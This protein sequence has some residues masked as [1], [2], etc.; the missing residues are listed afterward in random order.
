MRT[1]FEN[2]I[3]DVLVRA[4]YTDQLKVA[5]D[6]VRISTAWRVEGTLREFAKFKPVNMWFSYPVHALDETGVLADIQIEEA[7]NSKNSPWKKNFEKKTEKSKETKAEKVERAINLL[8]DDLKP[9]TLDD[10]VEYFSENDNPVTDK[11][12]RRWIGKTDKFTIENKIIVPVETSENDE[13]T[14]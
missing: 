11:T 6:A 4:V 1:H 7:I 5:T 8:S 12:I 10:L 9:I 14:S 2:G 3:Q 13:K